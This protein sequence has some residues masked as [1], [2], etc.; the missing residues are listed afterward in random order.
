MHHTLV[1]W[2]ITA[3]YFFSWSF[4]WFGQ[5][6]T[7]RSA[8]FQTLDC[9]RKISPNLY[10]DRLLSLKV[11]KISFKK[12]QR[13]VSWHWRVMQNFKKKPP[14]VS[15]LSRIWWILIQ[16]LENLKILYF[17]GLFLTKLE[18]ASARKVQKSYV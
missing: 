5:K 4:I 10:F 7:H 2:E 11:Y 9:S 17:S 1:S 13:S 3:L 6:G 8:K 16:A 14:I 12:V 18:N 15:K